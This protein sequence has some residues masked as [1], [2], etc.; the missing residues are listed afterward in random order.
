MAYVYSAGETMDR[1]YREAVIEASDAVNAAI[2]DGIYPTNQDAVY[3]E[4][5]MYLMWWQDA[6]TVYGYLLATEQCNTKEE[7]IQEFINDVWEN[8]GFAD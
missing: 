8:L 4:V 6:M 1:A 5:D 7:A 3:E 2:R